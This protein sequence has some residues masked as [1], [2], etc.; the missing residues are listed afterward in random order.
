MK[1]NRRNAEVYSY[2]VLSKLF[3][4]DENTGH[5]HGKRNAILDG[6]KMNK[7][8]EGNLSERNCNDVKIDGINFTKLKI[9]VCLYLK[10]DVEWRTRDYTFKYSK[11]SRPIR[12]NEDIYNLFNILKGNKLLTSITKTAPT[13]ISKY[14]T[15]ID[16]DQIEASNDVIYKEKLNIIHEKIRPYITPKTIDLWMA[17]AR[18][19]EKSFISLPES[20]DVKHNFTRFVEAYSNK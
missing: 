9:I 17:H 12:K 19:F 1:I 16:F 3:R 10:Q 15:L 20:D 6:S 13:N 2:A 8:S 14:Q 11:S 4:L 18:K 7:K 5:L